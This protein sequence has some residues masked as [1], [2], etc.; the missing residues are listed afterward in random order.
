LGTVLLPT[1]FT[2]NLVSIVGCQ[3]SRCPGTF[4]CAPLLPLTRLNW[5]DLLRGTA[6]SDWGSQDSQAKRTLTAS[7]R[8]F[9]NGSALCVPQWRHQSASK[10]SLA[11]PRPA[12][13]GRWRAQRDG[14]GLLVTIAL[15]G[16]KY[17]LRRF[18]PPPPLCGARTGTAPPCYARSR[19]PKVLLSGTRFGEGSALH[20]KR[21]SI[22]F[23]LFVAVNGRFAALRFCH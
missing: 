23:C 18:A 17:P 11:C 13:R 19:Y 9:H 16:I 12:Q 4:R 10:T 7:T 2:Q 8:H 15:E 5:R 6:P 21:W 1:S 3:I 20:A 14:G 22:V